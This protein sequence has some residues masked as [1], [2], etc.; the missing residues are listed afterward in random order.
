MDRAA[1]VR[2]NGLGA[3]SL[4]DGDLFVGESDASGEVHVG[5]G[6]QC[7]VRGGVAET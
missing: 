1:L 2:V 5:A 4:H 7:S 6:G 3:L